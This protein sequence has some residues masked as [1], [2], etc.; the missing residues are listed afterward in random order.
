M[1]NPVYSRATRFLF[2]ALAL[3]VAVSVV[4]YIDNY[5]NYHDYPMPGPGSPVPVPSATVVGASWFVF[6][7]SGA[8]GVWLWSRRR[9]VA[10]AIAL[11]GYSLSGLVGLAHYI[12]PGAFAMVWWRQ[13]HVVADIVCGLVIAGFAAWAAA[14]ATRLAPAS[15][16]RHSP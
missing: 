7:A 6:T 14:N 9:I 5:M 10:S 1:T 11:A 12:V 3:A 15:P 16:G 2:V 8:L 13:T 4:H